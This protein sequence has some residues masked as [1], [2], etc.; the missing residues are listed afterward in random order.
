MNTQV[1][2]N[3]DP[4]A[5]DKSVPH[6]LTLSRL[7][8]PLSASP[9]SASPLSASPLSASPLSAS[10]LSASSPILCPMPNR[11]PDRADN[12]APP[13]PPKKNHGLT[14]AGAGVNLEEKDS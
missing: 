14:Y 5:T 1:Y 9:L 4:A 6:R 7:I 13:T 3:A 8:P 10:P 2:F 11:A 12:G